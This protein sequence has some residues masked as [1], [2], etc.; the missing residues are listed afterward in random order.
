M[1]KQRWFNNSLFYLC[2]VIIPSLLFSYLYIQEQSE[3]EREKIHREA[4]RYAGIHAMSIDG[5]FGETVGRLETMALLVQLH[6]GNLSHIG[7]LLEETKGKDPRFSGFYWVSPEGD[8]LIS[9]NPLTGKVN[10]S[11][12]DYFKKALVSEQTT[13]SKA[14]LGRVTGRYIVSLATP[15]VLENQVLGVLIGSVRLD[16]IQEFLGH[17]LAE[18]GIKVSD[19]TGQLLIDIRPEKEQER[20]VE[21]TISTGRAPW[22]ITVS[23]PDIDRSWYVS[24]LATALAISLIFTHIVFILVHY[25]RLR[26]RL[27]LEKLQNDAQKM[28][29]VGS[30]AAS[31]AHEIRNPLTGIKGL[32]TLLSEKHKDEQD[33]FYFS[34]IQQEIDRI[35]AIVSE[36]LVLGKPTVQV[37]TD[38]NLAD[39][40]TEL[41]PIVESESHMFKVQL[42]YSAPSTPLYV[43][44]SRDHLKQVILNVTKNALEA[45]P[46]GGILSIAAYR[47][48][49][50]CV[51]SIKDTGDGIPLDVIKKIFDPFFTLKKHGT[52]LGLV[53]CKRI[54]EMYGGSIEIQSTP[55]AGTEVEIF[56]PLSNKPNS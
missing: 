18:E 56:L 47:R 21:A 17:S 28:E 1:T 9:T 51:I 27:N 4:Q 12:R 6:K 2:I 14:H 43:T 54:I 16:Y 46:N 3:K 29:L 11:D 20:L 34:V 35:N 23:F 49:N 22:N 41:A 40:L 25:D 37:L 36:F 5:F 13:A 52:G 42:S 44:C 24:T 26:R 8:I 30:L 48:D 19:Q 53:I 45:M 39:V 31:T 38:I 7:Y 33:Q 55:R 10:L 50:Q 32:T 15:V